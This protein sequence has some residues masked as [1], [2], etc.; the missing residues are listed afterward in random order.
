MCPASPVRH[1]MSDPSG[2]FREVQS[3]NG[4]VKF[5]ED[6]N[7]ALLIL[8]SAVHL[9]FHRPNSRSLGFLPNY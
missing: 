6:H 3:E 1:A 5:W 8:T 9:R 2:Q 7:D 4:P